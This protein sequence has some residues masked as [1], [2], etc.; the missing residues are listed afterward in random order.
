MKMF[1]VLLATGLILGSITTKPAQAQGQDASETSYTDYVQT[2]YASQNGLPCGEAN[3]IAQTVD[4]ILWIGTYA[5]LYRYNGRD[6][7]WMDN[8][9]SVRNVNCLYVDEEGRLWI[10]TND[11]GISIVINDE[12]ANVID[13]DD[14]LPSNSVRSIIR[15][16]D[17][18][19]YIGTTDSMQVLTLNNGLKRVNTL[20]EIFYADR[21]SADEQGHVAAVTNG[22][23]L[24]LLEKGRVLASR[25]MTDGKTAFKSCYF[26][27]AGQLLAATTGDE[28]YVF[29]ISN[30]IFEQ[31]DV[32]STGELSSIKDMLAL[33]SG[34]LLI[35]A[36]N[37]IGYIGEDG[38]FVYINTNEFNNSIDHVLV[39]YQ[40]NMWFT[41]SRLG[42]LRMAP[43]DFRDIYST[44][45]MENRVV[46]TIIKWQDAYYFGTDK[47]LDAVDLSGRNAITNKLTEQLD[48]VRIR[49][50]I[51]DSDDHLWICTYGNGLLEVEPDGTQYVYDA[52]HGGFGNRA[53]VVK[54]LSDGTIVAAGDTDLT[55]IRDHKIEQAVEYEEGQIS[56]MIRSFRLFPMRRASRSNGLASWPTVCRCSSM[57]R[58]AGTSRIICRSQWRS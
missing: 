40:G 29:D 41:S 1:A 38:Q 25:Q 13:E 17:G 33:D 26:N 3:D 53:R 6:F 5:G 39:D 54:Q 28:I 7:L 23:V 16:S 20:S 27:Q 36:D 56:S 9:D 51:T 8:Y 44:A 12:I 48:G 47:G 15:S 52:T 30:G 50:M 31:V 24:Y 11:N 35:T 49:C 57:Q 42:L 4:G 55:F 46:N 37:G 10:G 34:E 19:Y 22:G 58:M 18:Y 32:L 2:I 45:G 14:G 43:S 21:S